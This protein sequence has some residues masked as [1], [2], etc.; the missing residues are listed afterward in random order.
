MLHTAVDT[1]ASSLARVTVSEPS[2]DDLWRLVLVHLS[3]ADLSTVCQLNRRFL[4]LATA[5]SVY[6]ERVARARP[7]LARES[8]GVPALSWRRRWRNMRAAEA[9]LKPVAMDG[10]QVFGGA[11]VLRLAS[12]PMDGIVVFYRQSDDSV[13]GWPSGWT[14][15]RKDVCSVR[16]A[17]LQATVVSL[18]GMEIGFVDDG[19]DADGVPRLIVLCART[20]RRLRQVALEVEGRTLTPWPREAAAGVSCA[21]FALG[22]GIRGNLLV[23]VTD[24]ED[25]RFLDSGNG[26]SVAVWRGLQKPFNWMVRSACPSSDQGY[27]V[28]CVIQLV[29]RGGPVSCRDGHVLNSKSAILKSYRV[30]E[31]E[32]GAVVT[33]IRYLGKSQCM[34]PIDV[35]LTWEKGARRGDHLTREARTIAFRSISKDADTWPMVSFLFPGPFSEKIPVATVSSVSAESNTCSV[36]WNGRLD[37]SRDLRDASSSFVVIDDNVFAIRPIHSV[38]FGG[39]VRTFEVTEQGCIEHRHLKYQRVGVRRFSAGHFA[40]RLLLTTTGAGT[41]SS[42]DCEA[43]ICHGT[44]VIEGEAN[45]VDS[46]LLHEHALIVI[47]GQKADNVRV[48]HFDGFCQ[49]V[50][51]PQCCRHQDVL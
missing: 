5:E 36:L 28:D 35:V 3:P 24:G 42:F 26:A 23:V 22:G 39:P 37:S 21:P 19:A 2:P 10:F 38:L 4:A 40:G 45:L 11:G 44:L 29:D 1:A 13:V 12:F 46:F 33:L 17:E 27:R 51:F 6:R 15:R 48:F 32:S 9:Q 14:Q 7:L 49:D 47:L 25:V 18:S 41:V 8:V 50:P 34:E 16:P 20:G 43:S 30:V 31:V